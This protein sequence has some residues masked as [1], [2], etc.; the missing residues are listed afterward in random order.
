MVHLTP[1]G[2][3]LEDLVPRAYWEYKD[4]FSKDTFDK[5]PARKPWDHGIELLPGAE[6]QSS[7]TF[8]LSPLEQK[9]LDEFLQENLCS[10]RI[11]LSKSPFGAPVFFIKKK[12][13]SLRLVQDYWKLNTVTVKNSYHCPSFWT[14]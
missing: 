13:G 11:R 14:F 5:L 4:V 10:G 12:D 6:P 1:T 8:P 7:R 2:Q 9:E 3:S